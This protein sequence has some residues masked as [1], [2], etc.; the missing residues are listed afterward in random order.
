MT[1]KPTK[2]EQSKHAKHYCRRI[3]QMGKGPEMRERNLKGSK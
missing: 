2:T 3:G 1:A